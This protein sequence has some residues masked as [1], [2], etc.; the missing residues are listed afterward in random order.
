MTVNV[1]YGPEG[2]IRVF[3]DNV[4]DYIEFTPLMCAIIDTS[5]NNA[6]L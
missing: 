5:V 3:K 1:P 4:F 6:L 2:D